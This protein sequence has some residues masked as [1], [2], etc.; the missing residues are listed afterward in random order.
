MKAGETEG[1]DSTSWTY[2]DYDHN[3]DV[4]FTVAGCN[5]KAQTESGEQSD[6]VTATYDSSKYAQKIPILGYHKVVTDEEEVSEAHE[7]RTD[8]QG[9]GAG[10]TAQI[11]QG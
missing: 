9:V 7:D 4:T 1:A 2:E 5:S 6:P 8:H 10:V 11:P 3:T